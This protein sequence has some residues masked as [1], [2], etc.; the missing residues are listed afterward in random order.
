MMKDRNTK[1]SEIKWMITDNSSATATCYHGYYG[2]KRNI[3]YIG[4]EYDSNRALCNRKFGISEDGESFIHID[5]VEQN[6][7]KRNQVCQKCLK[8]YD[9]LPK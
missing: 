6:G 1:Q 8:I 2:S 4:E 3:P 9:K 5:K 7:L